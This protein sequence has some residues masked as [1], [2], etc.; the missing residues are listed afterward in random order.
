LGKGSTFY[1]TLPMAKGDKREVQFQF[2]LDREF[3]RAEGHHSP[4]TLFLIEVMDQRAKV[5][6]A[7]V[8]QLEEKVKR[9]LYREA[10]IVVR[11]GD[12][13]LLAA[14]CEADLKGAQVIRRRIEEQIQRHPVKGRATPPAIS[15]QSGDGHLPRRC[16]FRRGTVRESQRTSGRV[17]NEHEEDFICG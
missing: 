8:G 15:S 6:D 4:L 12:P 7:L 11:G 13:K 9:S 5:R 3:R 2:I 14:L 17:R 1:F 16:C 10:D